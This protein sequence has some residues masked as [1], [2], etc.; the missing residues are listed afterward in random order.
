MYGSWDPNV[1]TFGVAMLPL[2]NTLAGYL[3]KTM[4]ISSEQCCKVTPVLPQKGKM[5]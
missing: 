1:M 5:D 3:V 2:S 4:V